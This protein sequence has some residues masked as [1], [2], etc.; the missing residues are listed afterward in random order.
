MINALF[1]T[2]AVTAGYLIKLRLDNSFKVPERPED[3]SYKGDQCVGNAESYRLGMNPTPCTSTKTRC[4]MLVA[5]SKQ[6]GPFGVHKAVPLCDV[7]LAE[8]ERKHQEMQEQQP[9]AWQTNIFP[10]TGPNTRKYLH[11][12]KP[13]DVHRK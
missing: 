12:P 8:A 1:V 4:V 3:W 5:S 11:E 9:T 6:H 7:H 10:M 13:W 2:G